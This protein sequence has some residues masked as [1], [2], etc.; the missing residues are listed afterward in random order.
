VD[1]NAVLKQHQGAEGTITP[2]RSAVISE[3]LKSGGETMNR[4]MIL[5]MAVGCLVFLLAACQ[6][7]DTQTPN[8]GLANPASRNCVDK[9][10]RLDI[11]KDDDSGEYGVC[12]FRDGTECEEWE[13]YRGECKQGD[14]QSVIAP[15]SEATSQP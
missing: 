1:D 14:H 6:N 15:T 4:K 13:F 3:I 11:R 8:T 2:V 9:G 7:T 5:F 10:G 12:M